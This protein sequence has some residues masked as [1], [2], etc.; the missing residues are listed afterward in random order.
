[1]LFDQRDLDG[2]LTAFRVSLAV[3]RRLGQDDPSNAG[4]QRDLS[5]SHN[6]MGDAR[7]AQSDL[8]SALQAYQ[9][10]LTVRERLALANM[11]AFKSRHS[12]G[13]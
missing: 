7:L 8:G 9:A 12:E 1:M 3:M 10:S 13:H 11:E 5:V 2:A 6:K 4:W